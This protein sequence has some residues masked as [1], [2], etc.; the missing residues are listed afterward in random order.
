MCNF[1]TSNCSCVSSGQHEKY[2]WKDETT[3]AIKCPLF[4]P[5]VASPRSRCVRWTKREMHFYGWQK[6]PFLLQAVSPALD[7]TSIF[8]SI[9]F[10]RGGFR[11]RQRASEQGWIKESSQQLWG[12]A[13][14]V[15][16]VAAPPPPH[17]SGNVAADAWYAARR[18]VFVS[19]T[20]T[21]SI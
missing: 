15:S 13:P 18:G 10:H 5:S 17:V 11:I 6:L 20:H 19:K 16:V 9:Y 21:Q 14:S 7:V 1:C 8:M 12:C 3:F 2:K 4:A